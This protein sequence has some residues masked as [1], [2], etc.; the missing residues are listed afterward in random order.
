MPDV[1]P[2]REATRRVLLKKFSRGII[3][4]R[5]LFRSVARIARAEKVG[6]DR[7]KAAAELRK[8]FSDNDYSIQQAYENS[9]GEAYI[10]RDIGTRIQT[11]IGLLEE[12]DAE[13]LEPN[14]REQLEDLV[15][16][17]KELFRGTR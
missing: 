11:L 1:I 15:N 6:I 2:N 7:K 5:V 4:N 13:E 16:R 10:E 12:V 8:L 17:I 14:V 9:V 3:D